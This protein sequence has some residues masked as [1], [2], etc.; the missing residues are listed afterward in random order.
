VLE[1]E[2]NS[3]TRFPGSATADR[4]HHYHY[5]SLIVLHDAINIGGRA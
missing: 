5:G 4:I 3:R 2:S 1:R